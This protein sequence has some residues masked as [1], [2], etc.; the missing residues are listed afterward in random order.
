MPRPLRG[1]PQLAQQPECL[2]LFRGVLG[3][4]AHRHES[5]H[6]QSRPEPAMAS[7]SAGRPVRLHPTLL[8]LAGAVH[9]DQH[10]C[11][12]PASDP[13]VQLGGQLA[14]VQRMDQ[15]EP[16]GRVPGLVA[17]QRADQVPLD[18]HS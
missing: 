9:L 3:E 12:A 10:P 11:R 17:L 2:P 1:I 14:S 7:S 16:P 5:A 13:A 6:V 4:R 18:R 8:R 15:R